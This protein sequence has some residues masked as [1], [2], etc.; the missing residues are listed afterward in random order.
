MLRIRPDLAFEGGPSLAPSRRRE[1]LLY[2]L[3]A[4]LGLALFVTPWASRL[5]D[6][7][8]SVAA[9]LGFEHQ[10]QPPL[11]PVPAADYQFPGIHWS[12]GATALAALAGCVVVFG[13]ALALG[14]LVV[15]EQD[16]K[17]TVACR[18]S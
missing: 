16:E 14:R 1:I 8:E 7:L 2:G 5:P 11:L 12:L 9:L 18:G 4:V 10:A 13:L 3:L 6:G 15:R 17:T